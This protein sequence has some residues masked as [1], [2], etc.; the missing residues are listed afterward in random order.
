MTTY[1]AADIANMALA[2]IGV[3]N[4]IS[5]LSTDDSDEADAVNA[6]LSITREQ[7]LRDFPWPFATYTADSTLITT[8]ATNAFALYQED[9]DEEWSFAYVYPTDCVEVRRIQ[10][11]LRNDTVT[12][13]VPYRIKFYGTTTTAT[14]RLIYTDIEDAILEYTALVT[15]TSIYPP[16]FVMAWSYRI[17]WHIAPRLANNYTPDMTKNLMQLYA[18]QIGKAKANS[19]NEEQQDRPPEAEWIQNR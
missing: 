6:F 13:R 15:D 1:S 10:S 12:S 16:D 2:H 14:G 19:G 17:A 18:I 3:S 11:G 7:T 8:A 4:W 9:P 5:N